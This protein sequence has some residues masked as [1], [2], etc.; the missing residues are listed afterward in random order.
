MK[1]NFIITL[2]ILAVFGIIFIILYSLNNKKKLETRE[3][4]A[5]N[6]ENKA[7]GAKDYIDS[8]TAGLNA[9][10]GIFK[11]NPQPQQIASSGGSGGVAYNNIA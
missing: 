3:T 6:D 5:S 1:R 2:S 9:L 11:K 8:V 4:Y 7:V 10:G